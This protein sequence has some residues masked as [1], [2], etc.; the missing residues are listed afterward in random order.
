MPPAAVTSTSVERRGLVREI[1]SDAT[2]GKDSARA[3]TQTPGGWHDSWAAGAVTDF[4]YRHHPG[5]G[6]DTAPRGD[7][8]GRTPGWPP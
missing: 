5:V 3:F 2:V 4:P 8:S 1:R 6:K 7:P